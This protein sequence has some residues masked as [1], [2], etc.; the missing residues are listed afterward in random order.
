MV[1]LLEYVKCR[2]DVC[3]DVSELN[4]NLVYHNHTSNINMLKIVGA[5][6]AKH[7]ALKRGRPGGYARLGGSTECLEGLMGEPGSWQND[8]PGIYNEFT[9]YR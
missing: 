9:G 1:E 4:V 8:G 6:V 5:C 3:Y 7:W 2:D